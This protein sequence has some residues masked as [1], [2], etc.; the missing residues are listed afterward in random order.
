MHDAETQVSL[1]QKIV[2]Q[3]VERHEWR[4]LDIETFC[5]RLS[6]RAAA[7]AA[8]EQE[9]LL[10]IAVNL[11]CEAWHAAC[12]DAGARRERAYSEL[13]RYLYDRARQKYGDA[14]MA[15]EI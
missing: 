4:L 8:T 5:R 2:E 9:S 3:L 6:A 7:L 10:K 14:E 13:A 15:Q 1:E 12:R 11:Y